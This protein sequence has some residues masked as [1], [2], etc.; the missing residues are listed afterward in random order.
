MRK[1]A[2]IFVFALCLVMSS[3]LSGFV[4]AEV[5]QAQEIDGQATV[6]KSNQFFQL[7]MAELLKMR[8]LTAKASDKGPYGATK[9]LVG[10]WKSDFQQL[11]SF[12]TCSAHAVLVTIDNLCGNTLFSG[13]VKVDTDPAIPVVGAL[14]GRAISI[15]GST[16][17]AQTFLYVSFQGMYSRK[18]NK[19]IIEYFYFSLNP[20][21][22]SDVFTLVKQ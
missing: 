8:T 18:K 2:G 7:Q 11:D 15:N 22:L 16:N 13:S 19:I 6:D 17:S 20:T 12:G 14:R 1:K 10:D 21:A 9:D 3:M 4:L 5:G